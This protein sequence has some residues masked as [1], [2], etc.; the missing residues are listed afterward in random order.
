MKTPSGTFIVIVLAVIATVSI[1]IFQGCATGPDKGRQDNK[2][3]LKI[4][5]DPDSFVDFK[6]NPN[7]GK[8]RFDAVLRKLP[9][10]QYNIRYKKDES[11]DV[12]DPYHPP[13]LSL[14]TDKITTSA[15]AKNEPPGDP[16][17]TQKVQS[18]NIA[19]I[20]EVLK[21]LKSSP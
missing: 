13:S 11:A 8:N 6:D 17:I 20:Q 1:I 10:E 18:N 15:L 21:A 19:D 5:K 2:Y 7:E 16:N 12:V 3:L 14:K 4:G 9:N